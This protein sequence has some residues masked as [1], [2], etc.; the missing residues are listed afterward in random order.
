MGADVTIVSRLQKRA[1]RLFIEIPKDQIPKV[2]GLHGKA[3]KVI[4]Q[5]IV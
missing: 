4:I 3:L 2:K 5:E 1:D